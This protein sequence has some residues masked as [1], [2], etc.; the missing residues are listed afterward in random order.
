MK[1]I[2]IMLVNSRQLLCI[3]KLFLFYLLSLSAQYFNILTG[4]YS[5]LPADILI[6]KLTLIF[7]K[8]RKNYKIKFFTKVI[9]KLIFL[10]IYFLKTWRFLWFG[11]FMCV[12]IFILW[13]IFDVNFFIYSNIYERIQMNISR[14]KMSFYT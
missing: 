2:T 7:K 11:H 14:V 13:L 3:E 12:F 5:T 4:Y 9:T 10:N 6:L 1:L 8:I